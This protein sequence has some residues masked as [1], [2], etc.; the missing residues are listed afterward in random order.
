MNEFFAGKRLYGDDFSQEQIVKWFEEEAEGYANL[1]DKNLDTYEY[2]YDTVNKLYGFRKI[3]QP[4]FKN[5]LGFGSAWGHESEPVIDGI[6][7][8]AIIEPSDTMRRDRIGEITPKYLKPSADGKLPF[9]D[10]MYDLVTC[11]GTLHHIPNVTFVVSELI[12]VLKPDGFLLLRESVISM[13][14]WRKERN[15]LT[16]NERG[17]PVT[18]FDS[19]FEKHPVEIIA[20]QFCFTMTPFLQRVF[21]RFLKSP[22]HSYRGYVYLDKFLSL[23][24]KSN[25]HYHARKKFTGLL[26]IRFF[27]Y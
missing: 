21:G 7:E 15:G 25:L 5:V 6:S 24:F 23:V 11:F 17:I 22:I 26:R 9:E 19:A 10:H 12:H 14:D 8:L 27:M 2:G 16:K 1:G 3:R 20:K 13:G 4:I 18:F